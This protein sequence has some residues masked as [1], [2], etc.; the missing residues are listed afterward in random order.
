MIGIMIVKE[1]T[2]RMMMSKMVMMMMVL[3]RMKDN[4]QKKMMM[5]QWM[6]ELGGE[7]A[8]FPWKVS[9]SS[10]LPTSAALCFTFT[11]LVGTLVARMIL[12]MILTNVEF[13]KISLT[14]DLNHSRNQSF[15]RPSR[16]ADSQ[17]VTIVLLCFEHNIFWIWDF[18]KLFLPAP[19]PSRD[20]LTGSFCQKHLL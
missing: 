1:N 3:G 18:H 8:W 20:C 19:N 2:Q 5:I 6:G 12:T 9:Y 4:I 7:S 15:E 16:C 17:F 10:L 11:I 13:W 14:W